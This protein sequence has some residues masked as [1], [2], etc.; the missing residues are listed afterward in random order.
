MP[1]DRTRPARDSWSQLKT[2]LKRRWRKHTSA[3]RVLPG[4]LI[5][6][7]PKCGTTALY[8]YL[9]A[10][11][12]VLAASSKEVGFFTQHFALGVRWY[13]SF[14]PFSARVWMRSKM[15]GGACVMACDHTPSY[16][17]YPRAAERI[18]DTIPGVKLIFL[19]RN[20]VDRAYSHYQH[21][22]R[23]GH[24]TLDFRAAVAAEPGRVA[25]EWS[26][27]Q[28]EPVYHSPTYI[29]HAY[30]DQGD[31]RKQLE[32]FFRHFGRDNI[33]VIKSED[34]FAHPQATVDATVQFL[35]LR[36]FAHRDNTKH[37]AGEYAPLASVDPEFAQSLEAH[38]KPINGALYDFLGQ[39]FD[40]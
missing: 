28:D 2:R 36:P 26:R 25:D 27:L 39:D 6:G 38:F 3:Y 30:L 16:A 24:E 7:M 32:P 8:Y 31:Y 1:R 33:L 9:L 21:E 12:Q 4:V 17:L 11:P 19:L 23:T 20:P 40:W 10:H 35:G 15:L 13:R 34:L 18:A 14:F 29:R 37:N 5:A 22:F